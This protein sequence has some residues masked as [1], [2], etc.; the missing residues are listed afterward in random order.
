MGN[1]IT[2]N[3]S[4][5]W[6]K[7]NIDRG[8]AINE[9]NEAIMAANNSNDNLYLH[10][11]IFNTGEPSLNL[12]MLIWSG[13]DAFKL[14]YPWINEP[15]FQIMSSLMNYFKQSPNNSASLQHLEEHTGCRNNAWIGLQ[16]ICAEFLVFD[17][18]TWT[19]F[20]ERFVSSFDRL[21]RQQNLKYFKEFY[22]PTLKTTTNKINDLIRLSRVSTWFE[23]AD[24]PHTDINGKL[25][26]GEKIHIHFTDA[27]NSALNID[28]TWKHGG[29]L[30]PEDVLDQLV[31]WGFVLPENI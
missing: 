12:F 7:A 27:S 11:S 23:R 15:Q 5:D 16:S 25:L 26:H 21:Q 24:A 29:F 18:T 14:I 19:K 31:E 30:L 20:H 28:G 6:T 13:Y 10:P 4:L 9:F 3:S 17:K 1:L 8:A 2:Y 22:K